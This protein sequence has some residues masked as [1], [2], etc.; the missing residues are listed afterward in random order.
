V[1]KRLEHLSLPV[2]V[3]SS[4]PDCRTDCWLTRSSHHRIWLPAACSSSCRTVILCVLTL[5]VLTI[6]ESQGRFQNKY[7]FPLR[8]RTHNFVTGGPMTHCDPQRMYPVACASSSPREL[9]TGVHLEAKSLLSVQ[10]NCL[11]AFRHSCLLRCYR[12]ASGQ[13][14]KAI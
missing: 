12:P 2:F 14:C 6:E 3:Y 10:Q 1:R 9:N 11:P 8:L 5:S 13:L 7:G 4:N